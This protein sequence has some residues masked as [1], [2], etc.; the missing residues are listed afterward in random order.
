MVKKQIVISGKYKERIMEVAHGDS[1]ARLRSQENIK[2]DS[3]KFLLAKYQV[4]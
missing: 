3:V 1:L 2:E 4:R